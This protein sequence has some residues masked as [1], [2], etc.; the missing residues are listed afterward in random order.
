MKAGVFGCRTS[1]TYEQVAAVLSEHVFDVIVSGG[2]AGVD[3]FAAQF[4]N[5]HS[6]KLIEFL[7][8]FSQGYDPSQY[9][10]RNRRI[11]QESDVLFCF[12]DGRSHG[13]SYT[14]EY[15]L[16]QG[17]EV[18]IV[19]AEKTTHIPKNPRPN[20]SASEFLSTLLLPPL[21]E[22]YPGQGISLPY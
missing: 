9:F 1:F 15:A 19:T 2:A 11:V 14:L 16:S 22:E 10:L 7:P 18:T 6:I 17:K 12:W 3:S 8:D 13:T 20:G 5:E 4:A 21:T